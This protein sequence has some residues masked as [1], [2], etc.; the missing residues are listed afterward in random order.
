M[1]SRLIA[2]VTAAAVALGGLAATPAAAWSKREQDALKIILGAAAVGLIINEMDKNGRDRRA[3]RSQ[4]YVP[5]FGS[6]DGYYRDRNGYD[7]DWRDDYNR[8]KVRRDYRVPAECVYD[9]RTSNGWRDVVSASCMRQFGLSRDLPRECSFQ[10]RTNGGRSTVY[11][12]NCLE[13]HG[14][15]VAGRR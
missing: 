1:K 2:A 6:G 15:R 13:S 8:R 5:P 4:G 7:D 3:P 11:G 12:P 14:W 9:V 10:I